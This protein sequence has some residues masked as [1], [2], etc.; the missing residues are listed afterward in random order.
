MCHNMTFFFWHS[1]ESNTVQ[2]AGRLHSHD[3]TGEIEVQFSKNRSLVSGNGKWEIKYLGCQIIGA[4]I[5]HAESGFLSSLAAHKILV[6]MGISWP[7][8]HD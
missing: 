7:F 3:D 8:L 1:S 2:A 5:C 4:N 6:Y